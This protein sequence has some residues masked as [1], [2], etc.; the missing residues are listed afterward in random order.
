MMLPF[1][2]MQL[3]DS[4]FPTGGFAHS[5]GL[6]AAVQTGEV[7]SRGEL[8]AFVD[9]ALWQTGLGAMPLATRAHD[10]PEALAETDALCDAFLSNAIANRAS[11][12]QGRAL[13][14]TCAR[15][16]DARAIAAMN[17]EARAGK[18][19]AHYAPAFGATTRALDVPKRDMHRLLV[20]A[21]LRGVTSAAVRLGVIGPL[22]AQRMQHD[23]FAT[24]E[25]VLERCADLTTD[26]LAQ[27]AP[28]L[29][30]VAGTHDR[31]YARL[32]Q[33]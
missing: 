9:A 22:D 12:A 4:A 3:A 28:T 8:R 6:E 13:L 23:G 5:F 10:A 14:A 11:R 21:A 27:P 1:R 30:I 2:L 29:D 17:D 33:S 16:F 25:R 32:F 15:V 19:A 20:F 26:D 18:I 31:L 7:A 24:A